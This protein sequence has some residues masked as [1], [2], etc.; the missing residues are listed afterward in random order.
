MTEQLNTGGTAR[1]KWPDDYLSDDPEKHGVRC[2]KCGSKD[3]YSIEKRYK[4]EQCKHE[5]E[6]KKPFVCPHCHV[7]LS[8]GQKLVGGKCPNCGQKVSARPMKTIKYA[9]GRLREVPA[10]EIKR[11]KKCN[12]D[13]QQA[14]WDRCRYIA[15]NSGRTLDFAR[16]MF[17]KKM[18]HWP[19]G[20]KNCPE[21]ASSG[22]WKRKPADVYPWMRKKS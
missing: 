11:R 7:G 18:G 14:E 4:C 3:I 22:D 17:Q 20:L 9:D 6:Q 1:R 10:S 2:P 8:P 12:A 13:S 19:S 15:H 5:W 21:T 16:V